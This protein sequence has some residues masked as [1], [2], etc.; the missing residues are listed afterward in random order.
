MAH[1]ACWTLERAKL[2]SEFPEEA[3]SEFT[4]HGLRPF[5]PQFASPEQVLGETYLNRVGYLFAGSPALSDSGRSSALCF[6][7]IQ[8]GEMLR[9][10]CADPPS[11]PSTLSIS[12]EPPDADLDAIVL[13][14]LR[15]S[16]RSDITRLTICYGYQ[17]MARRTPGNSPALAPYGIVP[18][19]L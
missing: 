14:A 8:Y 17:G 10:I 9:V 13:K 3:A 6:E 2:L 4:Q 16:R 15:R 7:G 1:H 12:A 5:T 18:V 11:K 19:N